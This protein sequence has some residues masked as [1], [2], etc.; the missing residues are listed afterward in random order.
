MNIIDVWWIDMF[1]GMY[2]DFMVFKECKLDM[3]FGVWSCINNYCYLSSDLW[4]LCFIE[5]EGVLVLIFCEFEKI[6]VEEYGCKGFVQEEF[7]E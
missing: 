2:I 4:L 7:Y 3:K 1:M 6:F 5:F